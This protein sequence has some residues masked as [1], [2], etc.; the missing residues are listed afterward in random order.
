M[1]H[2][3]QFLL[4]G[5]TPNDLRSQLGIRAVRHPTLPL[6]ILNYD[7]LDSPKA[8]PVVRECRGLVLRTD[9]FDLVARGPGRFFNWGE[10]AEEMARFDFA[11]FVA[12]TKEDGS[13]MLLYHHDGRWRANTRRTFG[14]DRVPFQE[15]TWQELA[16]RALGLASLQDLRGRLDESLCCVCELCSPYNRVVR[17]YPEPALFLLTA[18]RGKDE[19]SPE[20]VDG[21]AEG[22]F[23]RP[24]RHHFTGIN[25][26]REFL[27]GRA[28]ADPTFEGVVIRDRHGSRWKVKSA[29][30]LGLH[31]M[32]DE[33]ENPFAP[34]NL[35]PFVMAGE[36]DELL[37]YFPEA[38]DAFR[39][40]Q[41]KV[42]AALA[43]LAGLWTAHRHLE[44]Q[45]E[46]ASAVAGRS[47]FVNLLFQL[48]RQRGADGTEEEL[49]QAWRDDPEA[50]LRRLF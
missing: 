50:I 23:R 29:T 22:L 39:A 38:A 25:G 21:L 9:T 33:A 45:K 32:S 35:L 12:H 44:S 3:Q 1:L 19:L 31:R 24:E 28:A 16:A 14:E 46:F 6:V 2:T 42:E 26:V 15:F 7:Q 47:P 17:R 43:E 18:Y 13:L 4:A 48:R 27:K 41:A 37:A 11:D 40:C 20:Q 49:R 34:K 10:M 8:H 36:G 30:Y 5:H